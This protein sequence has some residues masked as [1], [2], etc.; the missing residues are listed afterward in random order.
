MALKSVLGR[1]VARRP[2][3]LCIVLSCVVAVL[4]YSCGVLLL[5]FCVVDRYYFV[6]KRVVFVSKRVVLA[7]GVLLFCLVACCCPV[8]C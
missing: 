7:C 1:S 3:H 6:L 2:S 8:A 5:L 4:Y